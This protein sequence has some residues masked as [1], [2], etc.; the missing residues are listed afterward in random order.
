MVMA[1]GLGAISYVAG[2]SITIQ[3]GERTSPRPMNTYILAIGESD[4]TA[5]SEALTEIEKHIRHCQDDFSPLS[6]VQSGEGV[7]KALSEDDEATQYGMYDET[8]VIFANSRREGTKNLLGVLNELWLCR[9]SYKTARAK[10]LDSVDNHYLNCWGNIP[11]QLIQAVFRQEDLIAGTLNRWLPFYITPKLK[12]E[13]SP[14]A[15]PDDYNAWIQR[16]KSIYSQTDRKLVFTEETDGSRHQWYDGLRQKAIETGQQTGESRFHTHAV[17]IAGLFAI[18]DNQVDDHKVKIHHWENA[19][20]VSKYLGQCYEYLFRNVGATRL[21]ELENRILDILNQN[22]NEMT[23]TE[24][25]R[26]TR[27]FDSV[28]RQK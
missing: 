21:G 8:S 1:I 19:L 23:L 25:N 14:H 2:R 13:R 4:L 16:L 5:K 11:T 10:G 26:K 12:T 24:L 7:L 28:E 6:N 18:A 22:E 27:G 3:T 20:A 15:K 17:K 9:P